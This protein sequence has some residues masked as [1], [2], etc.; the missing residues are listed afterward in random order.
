M[1]VVRINNVPVEFP[2]EPYDDQKDYMAYIIE[3]LQTRQ[4]AIF[5]SP[6]GN[7]FKVANFDGIMKCSFVM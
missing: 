4:N 7:L 1:P 2:F 6:S 3:S 5:E